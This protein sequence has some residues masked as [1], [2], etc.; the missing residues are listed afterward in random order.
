MSRRNP[1]RAAR[2]PLGELI[3]NAY[4]DIV[5]MDEKHSDPPV[6]LAILSLASEHVAAGS[7]NRPPP[8]AARRKRGKYTRLTDEKRK[9]VIGWWMDG[10]TAPKI[11]RQCALDSIQLKPSTLDSILRRLREEDRISLASVRHPRRPK[12]SSTQ[13]HEMVNISNAHNE[14]TLDQVAAEWRLWWGRMYNRDAADAPTPSHYTISLAL[15][16]AN[17]TTKSLE[18]VPET[19][20]DDAHI[21]WRERY[22]TEA[23]NWD[24]ETLIFVDETGFNRHIHRKRGR[25]VRGQRAHATETNSAGYRINVCA[26]VSPVLGLVKYKCIFTTYNT[27]EFAAFMQELLDTPM[28]QT[29]SCLICMDNVSW[30]HTEM[31]SDVLRAGAVEHRIKRIPS[32]SPHLNPIEYCFK[33]WKDA[34]KKID[35][36][37]TAVGLQRQID[38]AAPLVTD[39]L[40]TRC[41]DHVYRYYVHCMQRLPLEE[42]DPRELDGDVVMGSDAEDNTDEHE[43]KE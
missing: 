41:L 26:A 24:R 19:R 42:F 4:G 8:A 32:Y 12:Y 11:I 3:V 14:W 18:W 29:R 22:C 39:H 27:T 1:P 35:Q 37:T 38:D 16:T 40:V 30:H 6:D 33:I 15:K 36:T 31:V 9:E 17:I 5:G 34:I 28:L 25:S 20:N 2:Q 10:W 23:M 21:D 7:E 43:E 13:K